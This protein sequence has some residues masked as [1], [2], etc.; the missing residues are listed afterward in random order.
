MKPN[1]LSR[2]LHGLTPAREALRGRWAALSPRDRRLLGWSAA[3]LGLYLVWLLAVAPA[4]HTLATAP[5]QQDA[6]DAQ[7]RQMQA[8]ATDARQ[9]RGV[10]PVTVEQA[11]AALTAA[12][13]R[14]GAQGKLSLQGQRALLSLKG[15]NAEQLRNWLAEARAGAR[16]RVV[17]ATLTQTGPGV[18]DGSLTV[19]LGGRP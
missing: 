1:A 6:L 12:T 8:L 7:W 4:W 2:R 5:A 10:V 15:A 3:L 9:L 13:E 17:D 11:S 14:L 16:A 19:A 18:F